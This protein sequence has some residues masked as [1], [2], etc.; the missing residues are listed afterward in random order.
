MSKSDLVYVLVEDDGLEVFLSRTLE[1]TLIL[2]DLIVVIP[3]GGWTG[4]FAYY[5][6][7]V[8]SGCDPKQIVPILDADTI[9]ERSPRE[10]AVLDSPNLFR[11]SQDLEFAFENWMLAEAL[12]PWSPYGSEQ[13][14]QN[15]S[16][17]EHLVQK[18][19]STS[20]RGG[21]TLYQ[22]LEQ[23][24]RE[25]YARQGLDQTA[26]VPPGKMELALAVSKIVRSTREFPRELG[27][28][29]RH[30]ER[31]VRDAGLD[32]APSRIAPNSITLCTETI[33]AAKL[34]GK[35]LVSMSGGRYPSLW[36]IDFDRQEFRPFAAGSREMAYASWSPDG[37]LIAGMAIMHASPEYRRKSVL[38]VEESGVERGWVSTRTSVGVEGHPCWYPDGLSLLLRTDKGTFQVSCDAKRWKQLY[39]ESAFHCISRNGRIARTVYRDGH[40]YLEIGSRGGNTPYHT[41]PGTTDVRGA[42]SWSPSGR[43]V[44]FANHMSNT[45]N[46]VGSVCIY[47]CPNR[48]T[49]F[50]TSHYGH[51]YFVCFSPDERLVL[52][53]WR[54]RQERSLR[55]VDIESR[56]VSIVLDNTPE[57][58]IGCHAWR[59][60]NV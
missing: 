37:K 19:R 25:E 57:L 40:Y 56:A 26:F 10:R 51:P 9:E 29:V 12:I 13:T 36:L 21:G 44:A 33:E 58:I 4:V 3:C 48:I 30:L 39:K 43:Y 14:P 6:R 50:L 22:H 16:A 5:E 34:S 42:V 49:R 45:S 28:L 8:D 17:C 20:V 27:A 23:F 2:S 55:I 38:I 1:L 15:Y 7:L 59:I 35:V 18:A 47:D 60:T 11:L 24:C 52:F 46:A 41:V 53:T 32:L 31:V 54:D